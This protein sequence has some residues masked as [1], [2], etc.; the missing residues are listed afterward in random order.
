MEWIVFAKFGL[1]IV[2][3]LWKTI[4]RVD[5]KRGWQPITTHA[6]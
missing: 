5:E 6:A 1:R 3:L 2:F 4:M